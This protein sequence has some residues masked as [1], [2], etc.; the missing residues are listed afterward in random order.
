M[1]GTTSVVVAVAVLLLAGEVRASGSREE[2]R[3][4]AL[5]ERLEQARARALERIFD[6]ATYK[7]EDHGRSGQ[8]DVD[9]AVE[10]VRAAYGPVRALLDRDAGKLEKKAEAREALLGAR[11]DDLSP[12]ERALRQHCLDRRVLLENEARKREPA[13]ETPIPAER[14]Q[15][16]RT[17]E[18]RLVMGRP[19]LAID[20]RLVASARGHCQEMRRLDYF[21]HESP[22]DGRRSVQ[23]RV[24]LAGLP[25]AA[26]GENIAKGYRSAQAAF[27][28]WYHSAGHHRNML[29]ASWTAMGTGNDGDLWTQNYATTR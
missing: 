17:N 13:G 8:A 26:V 18:Y 19:A 28:G 14:E 5:L 10:L 22:T 15:V 2:E 1:R 27:D 4:A 21:A 24:A 11:P 7:D 9:A 3:R 20:G 16:R 23:E 6:K 29:G 12:W 25:G